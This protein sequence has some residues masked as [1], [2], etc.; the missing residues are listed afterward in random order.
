MANGRTKDLTVGS[1]M[2]LTLNFMVPLLLGLLFQQ[3]YSMVDTMVVGRFLGVDALAGVGSTGS[4]N[5]LVLGFCMGICAGFAIPVAQKFG[6]R[7]YEGL[8]RYVGNMIW[9][10]VGIALIMTVATAVLCR[11]ILVWMNNPAETFDYAYDYIFIIFLG[12]PASMLYNLLSGIIRSLGDSKAPLIFLIFSSVMNVILDLALILWAHMGVAGAAWATVISQGVSGVLCLVYLAG[13]FPL[14]R[15]TK[16]DLMPRSRYI[17]GLLTMGLPMGLQYSITAIGSILIQ[18]AVN[19]LG[20]TAMAAITAGGKVGMFC[21][22]PFDAI[23]TTAATF[24]G[25]NVGAGKMDRVRQGVRANAV[26]GIVYAVL[27]FGVLWQWGDDLTMLFLD[28]REAEVLA[29]SHRFLIA[30]SILYVFLLFVNLFRFTIQGLGFSQLA[31]FAGV[32]EMFARGLVALC[33]VDVFGYDAV[34]LANP[35]AWIA[36]DLFLIPAYGYCM[37][38]LEKKIRTGQLSVQTES[39]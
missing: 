26:L 15:L 16:E 32:F 18:T 3:L 39:C 20:S 4:V 14:L 17:S 1:P 7:D 21:V 2:R 19:G 22:C 30:N 37:R 13:N 25:Q 11:K 8:R 10:G 38:K 12:I 29:M 27:I 6:Q 36:A 9:L 33:L 31:V 5:F 24:A 23:G 28:E 34:C 35:A